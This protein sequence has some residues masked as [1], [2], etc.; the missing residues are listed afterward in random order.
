MKRLFLVS[1]I[2]ATLIS[3]SSRP[4]FLIRAESSSDINERI[5]IYEDAL[6]SAAGDIRAYY[7]LAYLYLYEQRWPDAEKTLIEAIALFP[8]SFRLYSALLYLYEKTG[9]EEKELETLYSILPFMY[10]DEDI[11]N[12]IQKILVKKDEDMA[13]EFALE[14]IRYYPENQRAIN[15]LSLRHPFFETRAIVNIEKEDLLKYELPLS[16]Y[17][18]AVLYNSDTY[19]ESVLQSL[20]GTLLSQSE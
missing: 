10:A 18:K 6:K 15:A 13:Y 19:G 17:V 3:C 7:N 11:R 1:L 4:D 16:E 8:D 12:R 9:D 20:N 2:I 5:E 14:T